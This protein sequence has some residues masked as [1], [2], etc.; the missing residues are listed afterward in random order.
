MLSDGTITVG[1]CMAGI[2]ENYN[3]LI[4]RAF[5]KYAYKYGIKILCFYSFSPLKDM[6]K[7]DIGESNIFSL[8]NYQKID[9]LILLGKTIKNE[10]IIKNILNSAG[11]Y[12][13]PVISIDRKLRSSV[14]ILFDTKKYMNAIITHLISQHGLKNIHLLTCSSEDSFSNECI[15]TYKETLEENG[16]K[17]DKD[18][19]HYTDNEAG[20]RTVVENMIFSGIRDIDALVCADDN[21]ACTACDILNDYNI[22]V[23]DDII[24][25]GFG[26]TEN[27]F[28]HIP[29]ITTAEQDIDASANAAL[30]AAIALTHGIKIERVIKVSGSF[31]PG[32]S[33]GCINENTDSIKRDDSGDVITAL[34][35]KLANMNLSVRKHVQMTADL[36]DNDSFADLFEKIKG[37]TFEFNVDRFLLV[38]DDIFLLQEELSDIINESNY[39][40]RSF[41][42]K[43]DLMLYR[44]NDVWNGMIDFRTDEILP[45]IEGV[46][47]GVNIL[48]FFPLHVRDRVIGYSV[49]SFNPRHYNMYQIYQFFMNVSTALEITKNRVSQNTI[50]NSLENKYI[51]DPMTGLYNRRGFYQHMKQIFDSCQ[52]DRKKVCVVS[53][54]L[55]GLKR[56]NDNFGHADGDLAITT[57]GLALNSCAGVTDICARFG[58]DEFVFA[59]ELKDP[60][61]EDNFRKKVNE[62]LDE[63][64]MRSGKPYIVSTSIGIVTGE[65]D[66][67]ISLEEYIKIADERMYEEKVRNHMQRVD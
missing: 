64:N 13:V 29:S 7:H 47:H 67:Q 35:E 52:K 44:D 63:F 5:D 12:D 49:L 28:F 43:M 41:S 15:N 50:I 58:G 40:T 10:K 37:Y 14:N 3:D 4:L 59:G 65:A 53:A 48:Q 32:Q 16:L 23:P 20:V 25:T 33:C 24:V 17:F 61:F 38:I 27:S 56:I 36:T 21:I 54:D 30:E 42:K 6:N 18:S 57:V 62:Y 66:G 31:I 19:V 39:Q 22:K 34:H 26:G 9:A 46:L 2:D 55:N 1:L 8:I 51:H 45:N 60:D 11:R